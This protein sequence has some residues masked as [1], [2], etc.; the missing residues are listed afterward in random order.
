MQK[1]IAALLAGRTSFVIAHR[2][3]TI[4]QAS[5]IFVVDHQGIQEEG[6]HEELLRKKGQYYQ[7]H[8]AASRR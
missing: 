8:L 6:T 2:L 1:G 4:K 5:R 3:S 7:L